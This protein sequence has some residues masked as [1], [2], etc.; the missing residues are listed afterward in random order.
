VTVSYSPR[1]RRDLARI[2][3]FI[4][5]EAGNRELADHFI[6]RLLDA[7]DALAVLPER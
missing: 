1:S 5:M 4:A 3:D 2:R 7:C 6:A